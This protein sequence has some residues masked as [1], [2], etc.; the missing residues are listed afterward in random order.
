[1]HD[2]VDSVQTQ[3]ST[4]NSGTKHLLSSAASLRA[5]RLAAADKQAIVTVFL[6]RFTLSEREI[7]AMTSRE[8]PVGRELFDAIERTENIR[9]DCAVLLSGEASDEVKAG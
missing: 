6:R 2:V 7:K 9:R 1:M 3:L 5:E 4:A 8:I